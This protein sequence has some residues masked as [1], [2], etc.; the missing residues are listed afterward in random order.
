MEW[1]GLRKTQARVKSRILVEAG[2]ART[3][4]SRSLKGRGKCA[5]DGIDSDLVYSNIKS[6]V[7][8]RIGTRM[9][10]EGC[11]KGPGGEDRE[12]ESL[13]KIRSGWRKGSK[14]SSRLEAIHSQR[15]DWALKSLLTLLRTHTKHGKRRARGRDVKGEGMEV[16]LCD[17]LCRAED[18]QGCLIDWL[19]TVTVPGRS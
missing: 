18:R 2:S 17:I 13:S 8:D 11:R 1:L 3:D 6:E 10:V 7:G 9:D 12:G 16:V 4:R 19:F 14:G 15:S 5:R